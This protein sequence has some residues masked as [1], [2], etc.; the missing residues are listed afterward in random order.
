[1]DQSLRSIR[2][3]SK[4]TILA[5]QS[6]LEEERKARVKLEE[7]CRQFRAQNDNLKSQLE[8]SQSVQRDFVQLSQTLQMQLNQMQESRN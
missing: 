2:T 8:T 3:K 7:D 6:E 1:M 5:L 4:H